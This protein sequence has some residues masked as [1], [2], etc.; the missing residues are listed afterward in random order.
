MPSHER[1]LSTIL[2][3][4]T[5]T[6]A[7]IRATGMMVVGAWVQFGSGDME[8]GITFGCFLV[9]LFPSSLLFG[10]RPGTNG[11]GTG[12]YHLQ[13]TAKWRWSF[14]VRRIL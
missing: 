13:I 11:V 14:P 2:M 12:C 7:E 5:M 4:P 6:Y 10:S 9:S 3:I 1:K 8:D